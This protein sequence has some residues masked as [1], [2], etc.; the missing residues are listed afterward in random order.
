M[1]LYP[2]VNGKYHGKYC[3][4]S[5]KTSPVMVAASPN[6]WGLKSHAAIPMI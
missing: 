1:D 3:I 6:F 5:E 2:V 4:P